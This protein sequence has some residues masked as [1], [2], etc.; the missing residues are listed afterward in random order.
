MV[1]EN[2]RRESGRFPEIRI[3]FRSSGPFVLPPCFQAVLFSMLLAGAVAFAYLSINRLG[4]EHVANERKAA[5]ARARAAGAGLEERIA[6]VQQQLARL[7]RERDKARAETAALGAEAD[8]LRARLAAAEAAAQDRTT[9]ENALHQEQARSAALI[10]QLARS[11]ADRAPEAAQFRQFETSLEQT[12][13]DLD[14]LQI[15]GD[16]LRIGKGRVHLRLGEIWRRAFASS[17]DLADGLSAAPS[18]PG[19]ST[20]PIPAAAR[21]P[22]GAG[23]GDAL[24]SFEI[25]LRS[26]GID[27][28]RIISHLP[29][30]GEGGPF[31]PAPSTAAAPAEPVKLAAI[32]ALTRTLPTAPPLAQFRIGSGFGVRLDPFNH[33][34]AFHTG[35]D[36][37]A[38]Y[39]SPVFAAAPGTVIYSGKLGDYGQVVELDHGFGI[40][41]LYAHMRRRLVA[42]GQAVAAHGEIG[43]VGS[44]G[45]STGPHVHYEVRVDGQPQDP[46]KFLA[47]AP[48]LPA[49]TRELTQ[50][51]GGPAENTR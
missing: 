11:E 26:A 7:L 46:K 13:H 32:E 41:T 24:A 12:T 2:S 33:R 29:A 8:G 4:W 48:L 18:G 45:R 39:L 38:P 37:D 31:V 35:L 47:L 30:G 3:C 50:A 10:A 14:Q 40:V 6:T 5:A 28:A 1:A 49:A 23:N 9:V 19:A 16:K 17:F 20:A 22:S 15:P 44:T 43:L 27:V 36:L 34:L 42:L 21:V 25:S 51:A